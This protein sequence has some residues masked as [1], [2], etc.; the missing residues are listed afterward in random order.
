MTPNFSVEIGSVL[1]TPTFIF[2]NTIIE[3][4]LWLKTLLNIFFTFRQ[5]RN[6]S[7]KNLKKMFKVRKEVFTFHFKVTQLNLQG[8][9]CSSSLW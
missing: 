8:V 2:M 4:L 9:F 6:T 5:N 7:K 1:P 3:L